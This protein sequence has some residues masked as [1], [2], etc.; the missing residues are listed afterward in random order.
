MSLSAS[1]PAASFVH[2]TARDVPV[3]GH[4]D[5]V[6]CGAGPAGIAAALAVARTGA[7]TVLIEVHGC[8]GGIWT[9]GQLAWIMDVKDK[10]GIMAEIV[11]ELERRGARRPRV[12]GGTNF[13]YD[14]EEMKLL[15]DELTAAAGVRVRLHTRV[16]AAL[17]DSD[18]R[19][20]SVITESKSGRE[21]WTASA[22]VDATGDGD[23]SALAGC[24]FDL[25]RPG[26]GE[27]QPM[28]LVSL[29]C[30]A[31]PA[32]IQSFIGGGL[33]EPKERL[34]AELRRAG[35]EP[36]YTAPT[37]FHIR[38]DLYALMANHEYGV[39]ALDADAIGAATTRARAEVNRI[40]RA[41]RGLGGCWADFRLV[42]TPAHIG[43][44]EGR[45]VHG[46]YTVTEN[47]LLSGA[48]H[49]D[50]ICRVNFGI[51]VHST[52]RAHGGAFDVANKRRSQPYDIPLRALIAKDVDGLLMAGR[53]ISGDFIAHSSYRITGAA[54]T[55]GQAAGV[56]AALAARS[57]IAPGEVPFSEVRD[58]LARLG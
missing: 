53:C 32:E 2:E 39:S 49:E 23:L 38:D 5:V 7:R 17:R 37:L 19:L 57:G 21:A 8:L 12:E 26:D 16:V 47:D 34:L 10:P 40:V 51:D 15:L 13:A 27:C 44:R 30:G 46:R 45:R 11:A 54:V 31:A 41:L 56:A 29:V 24:G 52:N 48:R 22:F 50:A 3:A 55:L 25:G 14:I 33:R 42:A 43:V 28:S 20:R 6:V 18:G 36:S 58:A 9:A 1:Q 4:A 35:V